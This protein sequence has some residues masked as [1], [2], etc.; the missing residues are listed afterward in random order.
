M[1]VAL[2]R[3]HRLGRLVAAHSL[4]WLVAANVVGLWL[5]LLL[6]WPD[7]GRFLAPLTYGRWVP[8]H[9]D[10]MLYGWCALP[11]VGALLVW[12]LDA[13]H[14]AMLGH[15]RLAL[16]AWSLALALGGFA[17]LGG[18][19][20]GKLFLEWHGWSRPVLPVAML[21]LWTL[22]GAHTWWRWP[23]LSGAGRLL[24]SSLLAG[25]LFVPALLY[26][27]SD[28]T[29]YPAVNPDS[30]G[31]TGTSLLGS[32]LG[33]VSIFGLVP[34]LLGLAPRRAVRWFWPALGASGVV[35][36]VLK[37]GTVSHHDLAQMAGL[38]LLLAWIPA[39]MLYWRAHDWPV[40]AQPWVRAFQGWWVLLVVTGWILF[41]PGISER[42]KFTSGLVAHSHL[43][44]A[45]VV[46][47]LG[48]MIL[49]Q[50][51]GRKVNPS[52]FMAWQTGCAVQIVALL[53]LGWLEGADPS[54]AYRGEF[55]PRLLLIIRLAAGTVMTGASLRWYLDFCLP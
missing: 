26:L 47:S 18:N 8:L 53:A 50:L 9:L 3:E 12:G 1:D 45:G 40:A 39:V 28:R 4:G 34:V 37:H 17:W 51:T 41:L 19:T 33:I 43:A 25:L 38:A 30:G 54:A 23:D 29:V 11:L 7:L 10:W 16:G 20:S 46:T 24:R 5:A 36:A 6:V 22:L 15:A 14:P 32:T 13:R 2:T 49:A 31:A 35:F 44:M 55:W 48:G 52:A 27:A 21:V 42:L